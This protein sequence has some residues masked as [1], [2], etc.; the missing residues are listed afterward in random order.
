MKLAHLENIECFY[1]LPC[2]DSRKSFYGKALVIHADGGTFLQSYNTIVCKIDK[3]GN[4]VRLWDGYSATTMRHVN[5]FL[6][7]FRISGYMGRRRKQSVH[8]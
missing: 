1:E 2:H 5:S 4:F 3:N 7:N 8:N 6:Q